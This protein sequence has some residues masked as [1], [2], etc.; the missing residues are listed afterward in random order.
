MDEKDGPGRRDREKNRRPAPDQV[1]LETR[2]DRAKD[3][4]LQNPSTIDYNCFAN[5]LHRERIEVSGYT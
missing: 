2:K 5:R 3:R 4:A 1:V